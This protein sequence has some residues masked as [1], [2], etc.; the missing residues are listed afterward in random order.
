VL[1][2]PLVSRNK[3]DLPLM[4]SLAFA[5]KVLYQHQPTLSLIAENNSPKNLFALRSLKKINAP[6]HI[7]MQ[8]IYP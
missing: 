7:I 4:K 3:Y 5:I 1:P 8:R 6:S 2:H